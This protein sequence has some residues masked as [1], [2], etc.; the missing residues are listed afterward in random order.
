MH[1]ENIL[2]I[3]LIEKDIIGKSYDNIVIKNCRI[4]FSNI[5]NCEFIECQFIDCTFNTLVFENVSVRDC[6]FEKCNIIGVNWNEVTNKNLLA[7][8]IEEMK[9]CF[10]KYNDFNYI[11]FVKMDLS[12]NEF[13]HCE[14]RECNLSKTNFSHCNLTDTVFIDNNLNQT[15]FEHSYGFILDLNH[16]KLSKTYFSL[17]QTPDLLNIFDIEIKGG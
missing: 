11:S 16:N 3:N 2:N 8:P 9:Q 17:E 14:Y 15:N 5:S 12:S 13:I 10:C 6:Y 1:E 4:E 7:H